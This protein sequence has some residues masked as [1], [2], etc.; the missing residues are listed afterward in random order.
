[1]HLCEGRLFT[2]KG[3]FLKLD[4]MSTT[5]ITI[6]VFR[7]VVITSMLLF[8]SLSPAESDRGFNTWQ[9][10]LAPLYL[11]AAKTRGTATFGSTTVPLDIDF[12][13]SLSDLDGIMTIHYEG[14]KGHWG[15]IVDYS[16]LN[17]TPKAEVPGS[18][19][20]VKAEMKN[21][22]AEIAA[23]YRFSAS[24]PWQLLAGIRSY[25]LDITLSGL[26]SPPAPATQ[27]AIR[28]KIND[29]FIGGRYMRAINDSWSFIGRADIGTGDSDLV[30]NVLV[31]VDYR[32]TRLLSAFAGWRRLEYDVNTGSGPSTF[33]YDINHCGPLLALVFHW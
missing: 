21:T 6:S 4:M 24:N 17:L 32:I 3:N 2:K 23:L 13:D 16:Y 15:I 5:K 7:S 12:S 22:I 30:W 11:W 27:F 14:A 8:S 9:N 28:E 26:S 25:D 33:K 10:T 31:A 1:M 20:Q 29:F 19:V 18:P